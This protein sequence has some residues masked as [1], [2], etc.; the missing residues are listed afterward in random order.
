MVT[1]KPYVRWYAKT[2][3]SAEALDVLYGDEVCNGVVSVKNK[4][5]LSKD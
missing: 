1:G 5:G 3:K 2:S 4:S